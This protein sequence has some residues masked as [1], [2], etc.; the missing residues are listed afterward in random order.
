[1]SAV[2]AKPQV[3]DFLKTLEKGKEKGKEQRKEHDVN[4]HAVTAE[5][6][7]SKKPW[8][9]D[10]PELS[11]PSY[12]PPTSFSY[13]SDSS[14][15]SNP[16]KRRK[17]VRSKTMGRKAH[18]YWKL[19]TI[20]GKATSKWRCR[21]CNGEYSGAANRLVAHLSKIGGSGIGGCEKVP[22]ELVDKVIAENNLRRGGVTVDALDGIDEDL[23]V[24]NQS[25]GTSSAPVD[26]LLLEHKHTEGAEQDEAAA[27]L[28][29]EEEE[30]FHMLHRELET[31]DRRVTRARSGVHGIE[32]SGSQAQGDH[33]VIPRAR[34]RRGP[35]RGTRRGRGGRGNVIDHAETSSVAADGEV[36][37]STHGTSSS[38]C[39]VIAEPEYDSDGLVPN[40]LG[41]ADIDA[42]SELCRAWGRVRD[43]QSLVFFDPGARANFITP[44][45]AEKMEI[46]MDEMSCWDEVKE[47]THNGYTPQQGH[48]SSIEPMQIDSARFQPLSAQKKQRRRINGLCMYCGEQG[49]MVQ[50]CPR[51]R[52]MKL[53]HVAG[54]KNVVADALSRRP[55]VAAVSIAYQ[56]ELDEMQDHY[57]T[58]EDFAEPYDAL[59]R[60]EHPDLYSLKDGFL[61]FCEKLCVSRLLR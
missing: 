23:L 54:K 50:Q 43:H 47:V 28:R 1:M 61:M 17:R 39:L 31:I 37:S 12:S 33:I 42:S 56:H 46:K 13:S 38:S 34:S 8:E 60:G 25:E 11:S 26:P 14:S 51:K 52:R 10:I 16:R 29:S 20:D 30:I 40:I 49:H 44:Q 4:A 24:S 57:S 35:K 9:E 21:Y 7:P 36:E 55:H 15:S 27:R 41:S 45:L 6:E 19:H 53:V 5:G 2:L 59:V 58:N 48:E 18:P 22:R 3:K 32:P